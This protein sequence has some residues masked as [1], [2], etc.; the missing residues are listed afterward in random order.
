MW[1]QILKG[2]PDYAREFVLWRTRGRGS[3]KP[4]TSVKE[5]VW[6]ARLEE[7][8]GVLCTHLAWVPGLLRLADDSRGVLPSPVALPG[9]DLGTLLLGRLPHSW[10]HSGGA[11][12]RGFIILLLSCSLCRAGGVRGKPPW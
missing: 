6:C 2:I 5:A 11:V 4:R 9:G 1:R 10:Q 12:G 7:E 3:E 8:A